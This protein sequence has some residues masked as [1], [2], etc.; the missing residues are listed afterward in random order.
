MGAKNS[1]REAAYGSTASR[2]SPSAKVSRTRS[3][4][5]KVFSRRLSQDYGWSIRGKPLLEDGDAIDPAVEYERLLE[6]EKLHGKEGTGFCGATRQDIIRSCISSPHRGS[7]E[8]IIYEED[9]EEEQDDFVGTGSAPPSTVR[10]LKS[11]PVFSR[12]RSR[13]S[14][15]SASCLDEFLG[16]AEGCEAVDVAP[17]VDVVDPVVVAD[18]LY[19]G[20]DSGKPVFEVTEDTSAEP[21]EDSLD[22]FKNRDINHSYSSCVPEFVEQFLNLESLSVDSD[23]KLNSELPCYENGPDVYEGERLLEGNSCATGGGS[24]NEAIGSGSLET[25]ESCRKATSDIVLRETSYPALQVQEYAE[26][27][28]TWKRLKRTTPD[29]R[30]SGSD[31]RGREGEEDMTGKG[32]VNLS[33]NGPGKRQ[34]GSRRNSFADNTDFDWDSSPG[35]RMKDAVAGGDATPSDL[36]PDAFSWGWMSQTDAFLGYDAAGFLGK[37]LGGQ[38]LSGG[39]VRRSPKKTS[40][41]TALARKV[42]GLRASPKPVSSLES[43]L[44][45]QVADP[46]ISN[47]VKSVSRPLNFSSP[48]AGEAKDED[49]NMIDSSTASPLNVGNLVP[50][51]SPKRRQSA[52]PKLPN[53][54]KF[55]KEYAAKLA[56][57]SKA[58]SSTDGSS[59]RK[60][61]QTID[62]VTSSADDG[63]YS[64][65]P[66]FESLLFSFGVG[67]GVLFGSGP[68]K[69]EFQRM[70]QLLEETQANLETLKLELARRKSPGRA[71]VF[72]STTS[73]TSK[74][75]YI[76]RSHCES[77]QQEDQMTELEAELEA[78][79]D[80]LTGGDSATMASQYSALDELDMDA[81][82]VYGDLAPTGLPAGV[83]EDTDEDLSPPGRP[84]CLNN[85]AVSPRELTRLLRKLQTARQEELITELEEDLEAALT[86]VQIREKE[87]EVW[88][89]RVR[90]LTEGSFV[91]AS[92]DPSLT[93]FTTTE[94]VALV[95]RTSSIKDEASEALAAPRSGEEPSHLLL[96]E[97]GAPASGAV[98][99]K[100][101]AGPG[102]NPRLGPASQGEVK[103]NLHTESAKQDSKQIGRRNSSGSELSVDDDASN[104]FMQLMIR[105]EEEG[106]SQ[107]DV[108]AR[109][110]KPILDNAQIITQL[111]DSV[112]GLESY[113]D[114]AESV[115]MG[116]ATPSLGRFSSS[117]SISETWDH[118]LESAT[119]EGFHGGAKR[120]TSFPRVPHPSR[121][122]SWNSDSGNPVLIRKLENEKPSSLDANQCT[123]VVRYSE[124]MESSKSVSDMSELETADYR[125]MK[126]ATEVGVGVG[127]S[128]AGLTTPVEKVKQE[129]FKTPQSASVK[130]PGDLSPTVLEKIARWEGLMEGETPGPATGSDWECQSR[131]SESE[132]QYAPD[133]EYE[134]MNVFS[135]ENLV[136][137]AEEMLGRMLIKRIVEKSKLGS[138]SLVKK[139]QS[140]LATLERDDGVEA[141][142]Y[143]VEDTYMNDRTD[144]EADFSDDNR[145]KQPPGFLDVAVREEYEF[146]RRLEIISRDRKAMKGVKEKGAKEAASPEGVKFDSIPELNL[147]LNAQLSPGMRRYGATQALSKDAEK[148]PEK[149]K[150][151]MQAAEPNIRGRDNWLS[152]GV[153]LQDTSREIGHRGDEVRSRRRL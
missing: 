71:N 130:W 55:L 1:K 8:G 114:R 76:K 25:A 140:A 12:R 147:G 28:R 145:E 149:E 37:G 139:A 129:L 132:Q 15:Q 115:E 121:R 77:E 16:E 100:D 106:P 128:R 101:P 73:G 66:S 6:L 85:Y 78:E 125:T 141:D 51:N 39:Y 98:S 153:G 152:R 65:R 75:Q 83:E 103:L 151:V 96:L 9:E 24:R 80:Q 150:Y 84:A 22:P 32:K 97:N 18:G 104:E 17:E 135:E 116:S 38:Q 42:R 113:G 14:S 11:S 107:A 62:P 31:H 61:F 95:D 82:V 81:S 146:F 50:R 102:S 148:Q 63:N 74:A 5:T 72:N 59:G 108:S 90:R 117:V 53:L 36:Q 13:L 109:D 46:P 138:D 26:K 33:F 131:A 137:E 41:G 122:T 69:L 27:P 79:L 92:G 47:R 4:P 44:R 58:E 52:L 127:V 23:S 21:E 29:K 30:N 126:P 49:A 70:R 10:S 7:R 48:V 67:L 89:D 68:H 56:I 119:P 40:R 134:D 35:K 99:E 91:S 110:C 118:P 105:F 43:C 87:L 112:H 133:S 120:G 143:N 3:L 54:S 124:A 136:L 60:S 142:V 2:G 123:D 64:E 94:V 45:A 144:S 88:K 19:G 20:E 34:P 93:S 57:G 111:I 86:K